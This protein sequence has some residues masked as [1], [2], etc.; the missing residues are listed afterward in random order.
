[1]PVDLDR[2]GLA[3]ERV[4]FSRPSVHADAAGHDQ[5]VG[6]APRGDSRA[7]QIGVQAHA[8]ILI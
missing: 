8:Q 6:G 5:L 2:I 3:D 1:V 7:G 4:Q